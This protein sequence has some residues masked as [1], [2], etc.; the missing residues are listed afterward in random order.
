MSLDTDFLPQASRERR[1]DQRLC[2]VLIVDAEP[3]YRALSEA[4]LGS[5]G[6]EVVAVDN[7]HEALAVVARAPFD[8][9]ITDEAISEIDGATLAGEIGRRFPSLPVIV[10]AH[11]PA[12]LQHDGSQPSGVG[13]LRL[14]KP[15][16]AEELIGAIATSLQPDDEAA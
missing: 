16:T 4:I 1:A 12:H 8:V 14:A 15:F 9:V 6:D 3:M 5:R 11:E 13:A 10:T 7:A 2:R